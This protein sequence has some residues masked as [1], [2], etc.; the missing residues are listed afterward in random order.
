MTI[1]HE[2]QNSAAHDTGDPL[3]WYYYEDEL[4]DE[5]ALDI[6]GHRHVNRED[7][8]DG[9]YWAQDHTGSSYMYFPAPGKASANALRNFLQGHLPHELITDEY[10]CITPIAQ[11]ADNHLLM[12]QA[13][14]WLAD[15]DSYAKTQS[16]PTTTQIQTQSC[17][18]SVPSR[19]EGM[20]LPPYNAPVPD[21][22]LLVARHVMFIID[23]LHCKLNVWFLPSILTSIA[24]HIFVL[25][26]T[27]MSSCEM[28][29]CLTRSNKQPFTSS[30]VTIEP[31]IHWGTVT[32]VIDVI[33]CHG[34][35]LAFKRDG[36]SCD[37][38]LW[39][40]A[41]KRFTP[42]HPT[43]YCTECLEMLMDKRDA[44]RS[45]E[46]PKEPS[47]KAMNARPI[48]MPGMRLSQ[49]YISHETI[50]TNQDAFQHTNTFKNPAGTF[51]H[52]ESSDHPNIQSLVVSA[53]IFFLLS[54]SFPLLS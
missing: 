11:I 18:R 53:G 1:E 20:S 43:S 10:A 13:R 17:G 51:E 29:N 5:I 8:A 16:D 47:F 24:N 35:V 36:K 41:V 44:W 2:S 12:L 6:R 7:N 40:L 15:P 37:D 22:T 54:H 4:S 46:R 42:Q 32:P 14:L 3:A 28:P 45:V 30:I 49:Q 39:T 25:H 33:L 34:R 31:L 52:W 9:V 38:P 21:E 48:H 23:L 26:K 19:F 50:N 27:S